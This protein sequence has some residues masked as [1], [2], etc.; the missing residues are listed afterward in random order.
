MYIL[1][2]SVSLSLYQVTS[3]PHLHHRLLDAHRQVWVSLL[4]GHCSFL[5]G[6]GAHLVL[7]VP[8]KSL[9]PQS[10]VNNDSSMV[11]LMATSSKRAYAIPR[12]AAPRA[13]DP[14]AG[15]CW[16]VSLHRRHSHTQWQVWL[17]LRGVS[18]WAQVLFEPSECLWLV[19]G[20][21]LNVISPLL[22]SCWG[23]FAFGHG[24]YSFGGI[25]HSPVNGCSAVSCNFGVVTGEDE[26]TSFHST[27]LNNS[28]NVLT[29]CN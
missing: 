6:P 24:L 12:S 13:P 15:H 22:S 3:A 21:I 18:W 29:S 28:Y 2:H 9:F 20:L 10:C 8:Y 19:W 26:L 16:L 17:S 14:A 1:P 11:G 25:Q 7:F 27:I 23:F 4:W 5:L